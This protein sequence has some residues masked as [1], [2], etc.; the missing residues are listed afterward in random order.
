MFTTSD[1]FTFSKSTEKSL[2][3]TK[4]GNTDCS[5]YYYRIVFNVTKSTSGNAGLDLKS[6]VFNNN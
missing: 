6:V 1:D 5:G 4:S 3:F 2:T